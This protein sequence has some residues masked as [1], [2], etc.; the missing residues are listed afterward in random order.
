MF[1]LS[2][3]LKKL[4]Y[5]KRMLEWNLRRKVLT[6]EENEKHLK[7]LEDLSHLKAEEKESKESELEKKITKSES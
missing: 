4:K 7:G 2:E 5:D 3:S 6:K 1:Y